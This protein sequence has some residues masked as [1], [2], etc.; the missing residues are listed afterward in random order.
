M[1]ALRRGPR[2]TIFNHDWEV[3]SV[4]QHYSYIINTS[5]LLAPQKR[6]HVSLLLLYLTSSF[7]FLYVF[8]SRIYHPHL[9]LVFLSLSPLNVTLYSLPFL[10][11]ARSH[12]L[13]LSNILPSPLSYPF[14]SFSHSFFPYSRSFPFFLFFIVIF[15]YLSSFS[16]YLPSLF[17]LFTSSSPTPCMSHVLFFI[18]SVSLPFASFL[19]LFLFSLPHALFPSTPVTTFPSSLSPTFLLQQFLTFS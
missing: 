8:S 17:S 9:P 18:F 5:S 3:L 16:I 12:F 19:S 14:S 15:L 6:V 7:T 2:H 1:S 10:S 13:T 11:S 4:L